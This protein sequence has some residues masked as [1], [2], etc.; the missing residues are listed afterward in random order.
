MLRLIKRTVCTL[1]FSLTFSSGL[2]L[3]AQSAEDVSMSHNNNKESQS[4]KPACGLPMSDEE[5]KK[6]LTP[7]QYR[8]M[9][10]T[11]T[12]LPFK[13]KYW[14]NK[15]SGIY[16]DA[17][18]GEPLFSSTDKFDSGT[19]WPSFTRPIKK[20]N[21][22]EKPDVS[23]DMIRREVSSKSSDSHLG[24]VFEDGPKPAG[25]RYCINSA[26]LRFIPAGDL[27][28]EG[29]SEYLY[30]FRKD[31][32]QDGKNIVKESKTETATFGAGCFWGVEA[33]LRRIKGVINT[34]A[35]FMGGS[36]EN[37]TYKDVC[38][39]KTGH[40]EVV[41]VEYDP[42]QVSYEKLLEVF[43]SIHDPTTQN[44]QGPDI[45]TQY[46]SVIFYNTP[47]QEKA[48][49]LSMEGL[50]KSGK[51]KKPVMTDIL[52]A[53]DFYRAEDYHQCYYEKQAAD[54]KK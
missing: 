11:G 44:R 14:N 18:T 50:E 8:I 24:H 7:E 52:P 10:Q 12:E 16:V 21:I 30:L 31:R 54:A 20:D 4:A 46:R 25:L 26:A 13:N 23:H 17:I 22:S 49:R 38:T 2:I 33:A 36:L 29:Y 1:I 3:T 27:E 19:G 43:W 42:R 48:A 47:E 6:A 40:A 53:K 45:G 41:Q 32:K 39:D 15:H 34:A 5:L 37:P 9:R 51:L 28:K 35:G